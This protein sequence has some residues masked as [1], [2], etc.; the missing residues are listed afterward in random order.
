MAYLL[1]H[2]TGAAAFKLAE[3]VSVSPI[4]ERLAY[5]SEIPATDDIGDTVTLDGK[6]YRYPPDISQERFQCK[7]MMD[8]NLRD[9]AA[10]GLLETEAMTFTLA[11]YLYEMFHGKHWSIYNIGTVND[12]MKVTESM[13][14]IEALTLAG[15]YHDQGRDLS[16]KWNGT[17]S[18]AHYTNEQERAGVRRFEKYGIWGMAYN[19]AG[20]VDYEKVMLLPYEQVYLSLL[21]EKERSEFQQKL[22]DIYQHKNKPKRK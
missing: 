15:M 18:G 17:L 7:V 20:S 21:Y 1:F 9:H 3:P 6:Q 8:K 12:F 11:V 22:H 19:L 10:Q 14:A 13:N 2:L 16:V 4:I 5:L